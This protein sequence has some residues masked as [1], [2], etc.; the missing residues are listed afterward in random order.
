MEEKM[1][2]GNALEE[3]SEFLIHITSGGVGHG[4]LIVDDEDSDEEYEVV[5]TEERTYHGG[6]LQEV[7]EFLRKIPE[8]ASGKLIVADEL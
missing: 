3:I 5:S 4:K 6:M 8:V 7:A 2:H 1:Y